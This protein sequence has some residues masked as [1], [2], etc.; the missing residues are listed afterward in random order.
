[1]NVINTNFRYAGRSTLTS[2][3]FIF[4][5]T[6]LTGVCMLYGTSVFA[7]TVDTP[8][9]PVEGVDF[10]KY[11]QEEF[12]ERSAEEYDGQEAGAGVV[13]DLVFS[14]TEEN[15][16]KKG[17][18]TTFKQMFEHFCGPCH[19]ETGNGEGKNF[20]SVLEPGPVNLTDGDY[21]STISDAHIV[22]VISDG[23]AS[24]EKS[25]LC[26]PWGK[27]FSED[28]IKGLAVYVRGL[29]LI[30]EEET[31]EE[32]IVSEEETA[33]ESEGPKGILGG[34]IIWGILGLVCAGIAV[35]AL[36]EWKII[37]LKRK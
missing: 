20:A 19:G 21:M 6:F 18:R 29:S 8:Y 3:I 16:K 9:G 34:V 24:V 17:V 10:G 28:R 1:M 12:A 23:T 13:T 27:T 30:P 33:A 11:G 7:K 4:F 22:Q 37:S 26:P 36:N 14:L 25:N 35:G 32:K 15:M 5:A 31:T 2:F